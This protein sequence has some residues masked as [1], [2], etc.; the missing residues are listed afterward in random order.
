MNECIIFVPD[1]GSKLF[2]SSTLG[3]VIVRNADALCPKVIADLEAHLLERKMDQILSHLLKLNILSSK[4][5]DKALE[6]YSSFLEQ[7]KRM[8]L[9]E[10]KLFDGSKTDLDFFYFHELGIETKNHEKFTFVLKVIFTLSH[11]QAAVERSF[12]LGKSSFRTNIA[13]ESFIA[14]RTVRN[15]LQTSKVNLSLYKVPRKLVVSCSS[16][17]GPYKASLEEKA[18]EAEKTVENERREL[19]Q[20]E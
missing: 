15:H 3:S 17:Y 4:D 1:I 14:K 6:Q 11:G 18:K 9:N 12:N 16:A 10:L 2:D 5:S 13:G 8:H 7:V 20:K 19:F